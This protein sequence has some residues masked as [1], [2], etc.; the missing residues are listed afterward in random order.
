MD[1]FDRGALH[2]FIRRAMEEVEKSKKV[3]VEK[4]KESVVVDEAALREIGEK[5]KQALLEGSVAETYEAAKLEA[6]RLL[7]QRVR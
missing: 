5:V 1:D 7:A 4:S 6:L 2:Y 3:D